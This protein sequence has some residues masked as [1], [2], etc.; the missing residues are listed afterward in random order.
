[1]KRNVLKI[2]VTLALVFTLIMA[3]FIW[4]GHAISIA[5]YEELE[6]QKTATNV[7]N[8]EFDAYFLKDGEKTHK[9]ESNIKAEE[10]LILSVNVKEKGALNDAKIKIENPNF[11][12]IKDKVK[13]EYVKN[14]NLDTNEI[15][16]NQII[17]QN[18]VQIELPIS[19]KKQNSFEEDYFERE[20]TI[21]LAGTYVEG[22]SAGQNVNGQIK[23]RVIYKEETDVNLKADIEKYINLGTEGIL[24][25]EN[26]I[27]E[28]LE[29]RLPRKIET[30]ETVVPMLEGVLPENIVVIKNEEKLSEDK[31]NYDKD[32]QKLTITED[33]SGIWKDY[34]NE[35]KII[36][37]YKNLEFKPREIELTTNMISTLYTQPPVQKSDTK[38]VTLE[39]KGNSVSISKTATENIYKGYIYANA[40][41]GTTY[42][43]RNKLEISEVDTIESIE[44][45]KQEEVFLNDKED[46]F[47]IGDKLL[48][49]STTLYKSQLEKIFG[50]DY[51]ITITDMEGN[52][53]HTIS[54]N[55]MDE[56]DAITVYYDKDISGIKI[57]TS[58]P[59]SEGIINIDNNRSIQG[60]GGYSKEDA[61]QFVSLK[62]QTKVISNQMQKE[63]TAI[64]EATTT[65]QDTKTEAKIEINNNNLSTMQTN[66]NV[67]LLLTLKSNSEQYDLYKNPT[68]EVVLPQELDI[69]VKKIAQLNGQ[70]EINIVSAKQY[71][72]EEGKEVIKLELQG[73]Q[74][75]FVNE[76]NEGIQITITANIN[77]D[78]KTTTKPEK[79]KMYYTNE[80]RPGETFEVATDIQLNSKYGVLMLNKLSNYNQNGEIIE[81]MDDKTKT[82]NLE[83]YTTSKNA[84]QEIYLVNNYETAISDITIVGQI[85]DEKNNDATF[86]MN[87]EK[88]IQVEGKG[89]KIY[90]SENVTEDKDDSTWV[91][92]V[93]D[94]SKV[95]SYKIEVE[96]NAIE[97]GENLKVLYTLQIPEQLE[98]NENS[99]IKTK[100]Y[101][102]YLGS[103]EATEQLI[104]LATPKGN[105]SKE[106]DNIGEQIP[107]DE[108]EDLIVNVSATTDDNKMEPGQ[109]VYEG[110]AIQYKV[111]VKNNTNENMSNVKITA[112]HDNAIFYG[113][114]KRL[115]ENENGLVED[116]N[117]Y[118]TFIEEDPNLK[119]KEF[120]ID[121]LLPGE[122][123]TFTY[124]LSVT[125][126]QEKGSK[127]TGNVQVTADNQDKKEIVIPESEIID[128]E[129]KVTLRSAYHEGIKIESNAGL[130]I[131]MNIENKM[132]NTLNDIIVEMKM[133]EEL[134]FTNEQFIIP[135]ED[136]EK[137]EFV[138]YK[139]KVLKIRVMKLEAGETLTME[140]KLIAERL[141]TSLDKTSTSLI[142]SATLNDRT[143]YSNEIYKDIQQSE[144]IITA[145]QTSNIEGEYIE[146]G[147]ELIFTFNIENSGLIDAG[148]FLQ[149]VV[150]NG[151]VVQEAYIINNG[152]RI[153]IG[154]TN[155]NSYYITV[156][157]GTKAIWNIRTK[158]DTDLIT[159]STVTNYATIQ[160]NYID[161]TT[162]EITYKVR[163]KE[164]NQGGSETSKYSISGLAWLDG[165]KNG[166]K[167][168]GEEKL[169][170]IP[171]FLVNVDSNS[172]LENGNT[173]TNSRG[174]YQFIDV[175]KG[176]YVVVFQYDTSKYK[177]SEY[178]KEGI[179]EV[180]NSDVVDG[181][182]IINGQEQK[183]AITQ[184]LSLVK[185]LT[186]IDAGFVEL[187]TFDL[188]LD[189]YINRVIVQTNKQTTVREYNKTQLAKLEL[190]AK[191]IANSTVI[192]EYKILVTN[193][194]E[195]AGYA[196]EI[197]DYMPSDLSFSS[198]MNSKWFLS[199][200]QNLYSRELANQ[201][202]NPGETK[203]ITLTLYKTM[204]NDNTGTTINTAEISKA[205]NDNEIADIDSTP[206]NKITNEDD[207]STANIIISIKTGGV[208]RFTGLIIIIMAI[209]GIAVYFIKTKILKDTSEE[210]KE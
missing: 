206:N 113:E 180:T 67:Q 59:V 26:I 115:Y 98:N 145:N 201:I 108:K 173:T 150:P 129:I 152:T 57:K 5:M 16:L 162:N 124:Q 50:Q 19:F 35:Y 83:S 168:S 85:P 92:N 125:D 86:Q 158:V 82:A 209:I 94:M 143:Y 174:E 190:D 11:T 166:V 178:Q 80:N 181:T 77:I 149:D 134:Y 170:N 203:E 121:T 195:V 2:L 167:D 17:Y 198:E 153:D 13:N 84:T 183:V 69:E 93:E 52:I 126:I 39:E 127:L 37:K 40:T 8:I 66:E 38:V 208:I 71:K 105:T 102:Q 132:Q 199:T 63:S 29:N 185:N 186:N 197:V 188:K 114:V 22:E 154:A 62:T 1:M 184:N 120:T 118:L 179:S 176:N 106:E 128:S 172:I 146:D 48:Y 161:I 12:I 47:N 200:D 204:N 9:K 45:E 137:Y 72:N 95:R 164:D 192:I 42:Q 27:T 68:V 136:K 78:K 151:L 64:G 147:D 148:V 157:A 100:L 130:P 193:E 46:K 194:G 60:N 97:K 23:T 34:K 96:E 88:P 56:N 73:E 133:P 79:I 112:T 53:L 117:L 140:T 4:I 202:I 58:K 81:N 171:V 36:Y 141:D 116:E 21:S 14:I 15:E 142:Y 10:T 111:T 20:N 182:K 24:L 43:E 6:T 135:E 189:K 32:N 70:E 122:T 30:I 31:L 144:T 123:K 41:K 109:T 138:E 169:S 101:Y 187:E 104:S 99:Y 3:D 156:E 76:I 175:P 139:D 177:V 91:E 55:N 33:T 28:V 163:G 87:L 25:Q 155:T 7:K 119:A 90:Y 49:K 65:L 75:T 205:N 207:I 44:I 51:S 110:E 159:T 196:S 18:N 210:T 191:S 61:K 107:V 160:G 74:K 165:N 54:K 103:K 131:E 89:V